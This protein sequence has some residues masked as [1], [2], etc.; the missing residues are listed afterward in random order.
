MKKLLLKIFSR[1]FR[2]YIYS[3]AN[4]SVTAMEELKAGRQEQAYVCMQ[5][6]KDELERLARY[7]IKKY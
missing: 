4:E 1:L 3:L 5:N 2:N 7:G 6:I